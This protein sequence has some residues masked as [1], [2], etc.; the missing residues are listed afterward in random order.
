MKKIIS[1]VLAPILILLAIAALCSCARNSDSPPSEGEPAAPDYTLPAAQTERPDADTRKRIEK[2]CR[3]ISEI[4]KDLFL[5]SQK[6]Q[7]AA[8]ASSDLKRIEAPDKLAYQGRHERL[9]Q[10]AETFAQLSF[11]GERIAQSPN[12]GNGTLRLQNQGTSG[13]CYIT[14]DSRQQITDILL[15]NDITVLEPSDYNIDLLLGK[16]DFLSF[17]NDVSDGRDAELE[18]V[19]VSDSGGFYYQLFIRH[20]DETYYIFA[21]SAWTSCDGETVIEIKD[22][23]KTR[24][25]DWIYTEKGNFIYH[26]ELPPSWATDGHRII[27]IDT[28]DPELTQ[29]EKSY[30]G[31]IGYQSNNLFLTDWREDNLE[32]INFNDLYEYL[33]FLKTGN[34]PPVRSYSCDYDT[35]YRYIPPEEFEATIK[36]YFRISS[37]LLK[38]IASYDDDRGA[39]PWQEYTCSNVCPNPAMYPDVVGI[40]KHTDGTVTL[41]VDVVSPEMETDRLFTHKTTVRP[42]EDGKFQY[43][44]N[45]TIV[46]DENSMPIYYPRIKEQRSQK[47]QGY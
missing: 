47:Y 26:C 20:G 37:P 40:E 3:E 45:K 36:T 17:W 12:V 21:D 22:I 4:Y 41:T 38:E 31:P 1:T 44:S 8:N 15:K 10:A 46:Y 24:I 42:A 2:R 13:A 39:Y 35:F 18:T 23:T 25:S 33:Y 7:S 9:Q 34:D 28:P 14:A 27:R 11:G 32:K 19:A 6:K 29:Y 43:V 5:T 30:I 16:D